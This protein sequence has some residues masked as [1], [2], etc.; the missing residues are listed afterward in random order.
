M[1]FIERRF[2]AP[3]GDFGEDSH[4]APAKCYVEAKTLG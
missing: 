4:F 2:E 1:E 3:A